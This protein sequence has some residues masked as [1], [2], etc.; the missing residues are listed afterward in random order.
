MLLVDLPERFL[1]RL[2]RRCGSAKSKR[3]LGFTL[4]ELLVVIAIIAILAAMLL[5]ALAKAKEKARRIVCLNNLKQIGLASILYRGDYD[6]RFPPHNIEV[7]PGSGT[8][9]S[10][11]F[12]WVGGWANETGPLS[13]G[14]M[15]PYRYLNP[16]L[17]RFGAT[18][19]MEVARCPGDTAANANAAFY[20]AGSSYAANSG[21]PEWNTL[22]L[23]DK[24]GSSVRASQI[25]FPSR[26]VTI[27]E[28]GCF[29]PPY[30]GILPPRE[31]YTHTKYMDNRWTITFADGH[32]AFIKIIWI[33]GVQVFYT[34]NYS[35]NRDY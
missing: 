29:D 6:D 31:M 24:W 15:A 12:C 20:Q 1:Q 22:R 14:A 11:Q 26:M 28:A 32:A 25:R 18:N 4:I 34:N 21:Y 19:V 13:W 30:N 8:L 10:S 7:P 9:I 16:Y 5:P 33:P 3:R 27:G 17:T 2:H 35:F 23:G